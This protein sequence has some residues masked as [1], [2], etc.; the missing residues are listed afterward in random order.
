MKSFLSIVYLVVAAAVGVS[1]QGSPAAIPASAKTD[2]SAADQAAV[3]EVRDILNELADIFR[4]PK[5]A[6]AT[7]IVQWEEKYMDKDGIVTDTANRVLSGAEKIE[8]DRKEGAASI[9]FDSLTVAGERFHVF[10]DTVV[11]S[12]QWNVTATINGK[13]VKGSSLFTNVF[14]KRAGKWWLVAQHVSRV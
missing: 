13:L 4:L 6:A 5:E 7:R 3:K 10:G 12:C 1:A 8:A 2:G 14:V 9:S 11:A